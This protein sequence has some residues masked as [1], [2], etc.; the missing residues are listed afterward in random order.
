MLF[1]NSNINFLQLIFGF[2][3]YSFTLSANLEGQD[4]VSFYLMDRLTKN[5]IENVHVFFENS[6]Y[7]T[8][9]DRNGIVKIKVPSYLKEDLYIS[10]LAYELRILPNAAF[11][12]I[13]NNDTLFLK[14]TSIDLANVVITSFSEKSRRKYLKKFKKAFLGNRKEAKQCAILNPEVINFKEEEGII[15][16]TASD[17]IRIHNNYLGYEIN[18]LLTKLTIEANGS[19]S[20]VGRSSF[21]ELHQSTKG[22]HLKN[23]KKTYDSS[24]RHFL[25]SII[26]DQ[27]KKDKY[28]MD[29]ATNEK[30]HL[31]V[32]KSLSREEILAYD[33]INQVYHLFFPDFLK[34]TNGKVKT[35]Q[36]NMQAMQRN[37]LESSKFNTGDS[38]TREIIVPVISYL[39]KNSNSLIV[40][41]HGHVLNTKQLKEYGYWAEHKIA[42]T[43]PYDYNIQDATEEIEIKSFKEEAQLFDKL[44]YENNTEKRK[45]LKNIQLTWKVG[46]V[47]LLVEYL[48]YA[49][50]PEIRR[51]V[52]ALL[53]RQTDKYFEEDY[54]AWLQ[55]MWQSDPYYPAYYANFKAALYKNLD[56]KF[57]RYFQ[58]REQEAKIRLDEIVWGGVKQDGIPPLRFPQLISAD[59]AKYLDDNDIVF[60]I[61]LDG[62]HKAYPKRILAWH[63]MVVD[64][65]GD[66]D[67]A[68]V[69]CTLCGTVIAYDMRHEGIY[70]NLGTSGFLYRSNKLMYDKATQSLWNTIEGKPVLG[71][72]VDKNISLSTYPVVTTTWKDWKNT[73]PDTKVLSL[74]TGQIRDYS[75]G[76]AYKS[77]FSSDELMFP[78]PQID[79]RLKNKDLVFVL[80][81]SAYENDPVAVS[82]KWIKRKKWFSTTINDS[83]ILILSTKGGAIRAYDI[84]KFQFTNYKRQKLTDSNNQEWVISESALIGP[85]G[86][87]LKRLSGHEI[88]WFAWFN[89]YPDTRLYK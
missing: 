40:D 64:K 66:K 81:D 51:E 32:I 29:Y 7:G 74:E 10:H 41:I 63:E 17:L 36:N 59:Q 43:L 86:E 78:V 24:L 79:N 22:G 19:V 48:H 46:Y 69:Y 1:G 28:S 67:I 8:I 89:T 25:K 60:G 15:I 5:P 47:S 82:T 88:F 70:H 6:T 27:L 61:S 16:A 3:L 18:Y 72:L 2:L 73:H 58:N 85:N 31:K 71:P 84:Q 11:I 65:F 57:E 37:G 45:A 34:I 54:F 56:L 68:G 83:N 12:N 80:R 38:G 55:W 9:S 62:I 87:S 77:Y 26:D 44:L 21:K 50:D 75:E 4:K 20:Y 14:P 35:S 13:K 33:T 49:P 30:D 52:I 53:E 76:A 23:R 39:F 42:L